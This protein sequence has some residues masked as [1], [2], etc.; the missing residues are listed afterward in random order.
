V[1]YSG[2]V[3][4][5]SIAA[6]P[7]DCGV[8]LGALWGKNPGGGISR[9][10]IELP[11]ARQATDCDPGPGETC[12]ISN[13][14]RAK[15]KEQSAKRNRKTATSNEQQANRKKETAMPLRFLIWSCRYGAITQ[16]KLAEECDFLHERYAN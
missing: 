10:V 12:V 9:R 3:Q 8:L 4:K 13:K 6:A 16:E 7:A 1:A 11:P 2:L 14:Q 5:I 15:S